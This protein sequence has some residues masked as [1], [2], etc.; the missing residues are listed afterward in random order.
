MGFFGF[1]IFFS[2]LG[3]GLV[4]GNFRVGLRGKF[5]PQNVGKLE[6][7]HIPGSSKYVKFVPFGRF[8]G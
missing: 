7:V 6:D 2:C 4:V 3:A 8:F 5:A 1:W